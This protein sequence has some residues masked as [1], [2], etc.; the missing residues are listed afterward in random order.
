MIIIITCRDFNYDSIVNNFSS[1]RLN[2]LLSLILKQF[3]SD[4]YEAMELACE[5]S[6]SEILNYNFAQNV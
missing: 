5:P 2:N 3:G 1:I 6:V 4:D